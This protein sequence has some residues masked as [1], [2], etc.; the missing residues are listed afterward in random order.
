M[1]SESTRRSPVAYERRAILQ[2]AVNMKFG[3]KHPDA[4]YVFSWGDILALVR[5]ENCT[6]RVVCVYKRRAT[7]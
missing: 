1:P 4:K 6:L 5:Y 3:R 2:C 7:L